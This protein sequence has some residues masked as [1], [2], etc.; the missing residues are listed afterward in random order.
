MGLITRNEDGWHS[1]QLRKAMDS[2]NITPICFKFPDLVARVKHKPIL[3]TKRVNILENL[4]AII[5]RSIGRGSLEEIVFRMDLLH[6]LERLGMLVI[7]PAESIECAVDK[8]YTL[9]LLEEQGLPIPRTVVTENPNEAL[10]AFFELGEDVVLKPI[11]GSRGIGSTRISD[12]DIAIRVFNTISFHHGVLYLQEFIPHGGSDIR[13]FVIGNTVFA[14][15]RRVADNWKTNVS[16]GAK[17]KSIK[18]NE[19]IENLALQAAKTI[20]CKVAGVDILEEKEGPVIIE[21][22][23]QPG[24]RGLQSV[25]PLNIAE[26]I[27]KY[28]K[29]E[30]K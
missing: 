10:N 12:P 14:A 19:E 24:W 17:T 4:N 22:N 27:V 11:F 5:T 2:L 25:T 3:S 26:E 21:V 18:L 20:G 13:A 7:N 6:R 23:S 15:M 1:I 8:Y 16:L 9:T 30:I 29:T 28:I